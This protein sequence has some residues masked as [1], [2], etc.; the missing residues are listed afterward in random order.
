[1]NDLIIIG[2]GPGG[3][4]MALEASKKGLSVTLIESKDLG[5]TCL[6]V[7]CIPTKTYYKNAKM[8]RDI[9]KAHLFGV[10]IN[11]FQFDFAKAKLRKDEVVKTLQAGILYLL[12]KANVNLVYGHASF[13]DENTVLVNNEQYQAKN[14]IIATGSKPIRLLGFDDAITS[15]DILSIEEVPQTLSIIG[16]GV[17]GIEMATIFHSF[18]SNVKIFEMADR[19][20]PQADI[21]ISKRITAYLKQEGI[22]I[23]LNTKALNYQNKVLTV[24]IKDEEKQFDSDQVLIAIGRK[25]NISELHLDKVNVAYDN[26]GILVNEHFQTNISN[27]Y[28]IGD[29]C[30]KVMLA[31]YATYCGKHALKHILGEESKINFYLVPSVVFTF[32]EISWI[33]LSEEDCKNLGVQYQVYKSQFRANGKALADNEVE[34]FVKIIVV[35]DYI[36]GVHII[37]EDASTLIH[38]MV[39]LMNANI[40]TSSFLDIIHAH[41]TLNEIFHS[42]LIM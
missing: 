28:A 2:A 36:K 18:G 21:E 32:P 40:N 42:A 20:L 41:P 29:V 9:K 6:N 38:E 27:I 16:G 37:G 31:H 11:E 26:R 23:Y 30:G 13:V 25:A 39:V 15:D 3:Y 24:K 17:I 10:N 34:G 4:E 33:G 8:I 1:M 19:L 35:D 12:K 5:G 7:G 14:I 22:E